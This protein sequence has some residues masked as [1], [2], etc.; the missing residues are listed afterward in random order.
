MCPEGSDLIDCTGV[1]AISSPNAVAA[2][3][4]YE[5]DGICDVRARP[6]FAVGLRGI[7]LVTDGMVAGVPCRWT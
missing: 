6:Q 1:G 3:C 2:Y 5:N 7:A 4:G